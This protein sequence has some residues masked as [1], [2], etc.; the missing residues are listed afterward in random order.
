MQIRRW[1][2]VGLVAAV[3]G[4]FF[5]EARGV[6]FAPR[7]EIFEPPDWVSVSSSRLKIA[8][9]TDPH[10]KVWIAGR[11]VQSDGHGIFEDDIP[12]WPGYNQVGILVKNKFGKESSK[13]FFFYAIL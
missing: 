2:F 5:Y 11:E 13:F 10:L 3:F 9:R 8:G 7:L 12:V 6:L 4:Y 1:I